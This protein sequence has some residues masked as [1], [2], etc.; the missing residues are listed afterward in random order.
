VE[1]CALVAA[2]TLR[3]IHSKY[4]LSLVSGCNIQ[5]HYAESDEWLAFVNTQEVPSQFQMETQIQLLVFVTLSKEC[6]K[7]RSSCSSK[8]TLNKNSFPAIPTTWWWHYI[9]NIITF[10]LYIV[11]SFFRNCIF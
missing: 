8:Q 1:R 7:L 9:S 3:T 10:C 2:T 4:L 11:L 6:M 5:L